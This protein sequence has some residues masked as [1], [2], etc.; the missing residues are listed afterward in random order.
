MFLSYYFRKLIVSIKYM[1]INILYHRL[2]Y[3]WTVHGISPSITI[4]E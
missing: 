2:L 4:E 3:K 1:K